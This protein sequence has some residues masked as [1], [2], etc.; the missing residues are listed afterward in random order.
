MEELNILQRGD[1]KKFI[2][3]SRNP[4]L[5]MEQCDFYVE[6]IY[7]MRQQKVVVQ[8][9][10]M[11]Y[12]TDG[13]YVMVLDTSK[14]IGKV[15]FRFVWWAID[16]DI[17]PDNRRQEVDEQVVVFVV[18][19]PNPK[20]FCVPTSSGDHDVH[21]QMTDEPDIAA[22]YLR[23]VCTETAIPDHGDPYPIY[24]PLLTKN[25]EYLYVLREHAEEVAR[26]LSEA[27]GVNIT[28]QEINN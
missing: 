4:I 7:G 23:L 17:D 15:T 26:A 11:L 16:T 9:S 28:T 14:M 12:G 2:I 6:Q 27:L 8:K 19:T 24:R 10:E 5:D 20:L 18:D 13:E 25:D 22:K 1:K 21:Y 3:T